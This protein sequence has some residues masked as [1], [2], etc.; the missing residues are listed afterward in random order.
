MLSIL[1]AIAALSA[2][3]ASWSGHRVSNNELLNEKRGR[4]IDGATGAGIPNATV[5]ATWVASS[6]SLAGSSGGC[7]LQ[8]VVTTGEKGD[9]AIPSVAN[10]LDLSDRGT[11]GDMPLAARFAD[12]SWRLIVFEP[13]YVREGDMHSFELN[14]ADLT[15]AG[16]AWEGSAPAVRS[17]G[18][19]V[20]VNDVRMEKKNLDP[21]DKLIYLGG[22]LHAAS[23]SKKELQQPKFPEFSQQL[24]H[25]ARSIPCSMPANEFM[26]SY[27]VRLFTTLVHD[28]AF[29]DEMTKIEGTWKWGDKDIAYG[30]VCQALNSS[31]E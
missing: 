2:G 12:Y 29:L 20:S 15:R 24:S 18:S 14:R 8:R 9:F 10:K 3:D 1:V 13:G 27:F 23:C 19:I 7:V 31:R 5:I 28:Q 4:V 25:F 16:F 30:T 17:I 22:T 11:K 21:L 26:K 6:Q